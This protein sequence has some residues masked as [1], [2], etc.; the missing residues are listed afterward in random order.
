MS[1]H[2]AL[3]AVNQFVFDAVGL[4]ARLDS[5]SAK[6]DSAVIADALQLGRFEYDALVKR[7]AAL[8]PVTDAPVIQTALENVQARLKFLEYACRKTVLA[9]GDGNAVPTKGTK[10]AR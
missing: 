6:D 5:V 2:E 9:A 3:F 8:S 4:A 10:E 1:L 7:A